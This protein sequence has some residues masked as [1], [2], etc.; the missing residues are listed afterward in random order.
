MAD[1]EHI[2]RAVITALALA[3]STGCATVHETFDD[4]AHCGPRP[5]CGATTDIE[6]I[7]VLSDG[8]AGVLAAFI[9][10]AVIDL[11]FSVVADT[12]ILPYTAF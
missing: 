2:M 11:P 5:Y 12:L 10:L 1:K 4:N 3:A 7:K 8:K 9:P 6:Y